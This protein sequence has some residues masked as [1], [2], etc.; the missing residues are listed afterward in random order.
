MDQEYITPETLGGEDLNNEFASAP[1]KET[2]SAVSQNTADALSLNELNSYL[3]K[4][5]K[6]KDTALKALKDTFSYVGRKVEDI[7]PKI[8]P[9]QFISREQYEQ[10]MFYSRNAE[11][12]TPE[13]RE[14]IDAMAK[15]KGLSPKD[16]VS[17]DT[18]KA[19][20][21]KVKGYDESQGL[22]SVLETNPRLASTRDSFTR[23]AE[24]LQQGGNKD[25]AEALV[26]KAVLDSLK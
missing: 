8:D 19:V 26:A 10:D 16:V 4:N 14:I 13:V 6:D 11:Y 25:A 20:F 24:I 12:A 5:F 18:F 9:N 1:V 21:S 23:A 2:V 3:G 22:R 17:S 7:T 15:A